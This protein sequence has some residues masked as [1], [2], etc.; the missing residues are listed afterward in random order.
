M[1]ADQP[2]VERPAGD[3]GDIDRY[4]KLKQHHALPFFSLHIAE[5]ESHES[6]RVAYSMPLRESAIRSLRSMMSE[7]HAIGLDA[8]PLGAPGHGSLPLQNGFRDCRTVIGYESNVWFTVVAL[9][10]AQAHRAMAGHLQTAD[11][12]LALH[13]AL[14]MNVA[15]KEVV[16]STTPIQSR[17]CM[18]TDEVGTA[19]VVPLVFSPH[20]LDLKT[21]NEVRWWSME[22]QLKHYFDHEHGAEPPPALSKHVEDT[23]AKLVS[24]ATFRNDGS[25]DEQSDEVGKLLLLQHYERH[26]LVQHAHGLWMLTDLGKRSCWLLPC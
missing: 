25:A 10:P 2:L 24:G 9:R 5:L 19:A 1:P 26:K 8:S 17:L 3:S 6:E 18:A 23:H 13:R 22:P 11:C 7:S 12:G 15:T 20:I 4:E 14:L 21:L 16:I